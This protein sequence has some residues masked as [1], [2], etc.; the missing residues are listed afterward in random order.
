MHRARGERYS[1]LEDARRIQQRHG[2]SAQI[3]CR[4]PTERREKPSLRFRERFSNGQQF[5]HS[6][7]ILAFQCGTC[8]GKQLTDTRR[9]EPH[10]GEVSTGGSGHNQSVKMCIDSIIKSAQMK[11]TNMRRP[12]EHAADRS[13][14]RDLVRVLLYNDGDRWAVDC[15]HLLSAFAPPF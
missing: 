11:N 13:Q 6:W 9:S 2:D 10:H 15:L 1:S 8:G 7:N 12:D 5:V 14:V 3:G 4:R